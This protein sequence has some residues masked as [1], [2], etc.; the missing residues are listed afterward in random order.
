MIVWSNIFLLVVNHV[1]AVVGLYY[2][3]FVV[4]QPWYELTK[5][6]G[7]YYVTG[8][9]GI[10]LGVHRYYS[11]RTFQAHLLLQLFMVLCNTIC[12]QGPI[13]TWARDHRAHHAHTDGP[14][15]PYGVT[16]GCAYAHMGW[17]VTKRVPEQRNA[18]LRVNYTDLKQQRLL[19]IQAR[20]Y[21][22]MA[23]TACY[24]VPTLIGYYTMG[25][26]MYGLTVYGCLRWL[27]TLHA[28]ALVNSLAHSGP[29]K[30][31]AVDHW[32]VSLVACGEGFHEWH[33]RY[34]SDACAAPMTQLVH[35]ALNPTACVLLCFEALGM[36]HNVQRADRARM[37]ST[38]VGA[39]AHTS[40][41]K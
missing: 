17:M 3:M 14:G 15:D 23:L 24:L 5:V 13:L 6:L 29:G 11:P 39:Q 35:F 32:F 9:F 22:P 33:H 28:T 18:V 20:C 37:Q 38:V 25:S 12:N 1:L 10:T 41:T 4:H 21:G 8:M 31:T 16:Q 7:V 34:P 40:H 27:L 30:P 26:F 36:V 2:L 19:C